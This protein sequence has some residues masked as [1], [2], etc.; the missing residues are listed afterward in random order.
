M[1]KIIRTPTKATGGITAAERAA[2]AKHVELWIARAM[3]TTPVRGQ[4]SKPW[5]VWMSSDSGVWPIA[6]HR[7][8]RGG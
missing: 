3:R 1:G 2:M 5:I 8:K 7:K 4:R 6:E